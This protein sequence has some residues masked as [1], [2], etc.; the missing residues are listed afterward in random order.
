MLRTDW[1]ASVPALL[2]RQADERGSKT[3]YSDATTS[4]TYND[5]EATTRNIAG[6]LCD[7]GVEQGHSVA[8]MLPNSVAWIQSCFATLR[9]GAVAV[10][11]NYEAPEPEIAY[12]LADADCGIIVTTDERAELAVKAA[13]G[14]PLTLILVDRHGGARKP[15]SRLQDLASAKPVTVP[16]DPD[17]IHETSFIVYTSGT[18]GRAKGVLLSQHGLLWVT[19]ACWGPRMGLT[20]ED[21]FLSTV[22][23]F[24][25]YALNVS[26]LTVLALGASEHL[27][28]KFSPSETVRLL[29]EG[30]FTFLPGVPTLFLYLLRATPADRPPFPKLRMCVTGGAVI[31]A[32]VTRE[33]EERFKVPLLDG[34]G[35]TE[36]HTFV[37]MNAP[38][39]G[40]VPGSCGLPFAGV[41]VRI[42]DRNSGMDLDP[43]QEGELIVRG[44]IV[45]SGYHNKPE[46]TAA[47]LQNGWYH[48]GDLARADENGF[49]TITGRLKEVI[50]RGGQNIAPA[51]IEEAVLLF[52]GVADCA[53]LGLPHPELGE[54]PAVFIVLKEGHRADPAELLAHCKGHLSAY[55][56][57]QHVHFVS[58]IPRT[59]SGKI[60]RYQL[61]AHLE[62]PNQ[63]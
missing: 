5:L 53:A 40:R 12:R 38:T 7:L 9:A 31:P 20:A 24:H 45:M 28:E 18:T 37:T 60:I 16:P 49:I 61:R 39:G 15:G 6:H 30:R 48:T 50:I 10:P 42:V 34:Y 35:I 51:E 59:G 27:C 33:F 47:A 36:T 43:N 11:I 25:S 2:R 21:V 23:L 55:K 4:I 54:V 17:R 14:R 19:A 3:A 62:N 63:P 29:D 8:I 52:Q 46:E 58:E 57:P 44:P 26:V 22:P 56:I 1:I 41:S 32:T 13:A